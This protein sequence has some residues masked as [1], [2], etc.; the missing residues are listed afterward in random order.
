[1]VSREDINDI[2]RTAAESTLKSLTKCIG[3][4]SRLYA[5][6]DSFRAPFKTPIIYQENVKGFLREDDLKIPHSE[7]ALHTRAAGKQVLAFFCTGQLAFVAFK[8]DS[9]CG[10]VYGLKDELLSHPLQDKVE[11][12]WG[13][14]PA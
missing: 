14:V 13:P 2:A 7:L 12:V 6:Y 3:V 11:E 10:L 5:D 1:M 9:C 8:D 4:G